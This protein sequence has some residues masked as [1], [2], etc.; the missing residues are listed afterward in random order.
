MKA[1]IFKIPVLLSMTLH[2]LKITRLTY[3]FLMI[4][5]A[6]VTAAQNPI[7][8]HYTIVKGML[9]DECKI[10]NKPVIPVQIT[11]SF[12][13]KLL[14]ENPILIRYQ[15]TNLEA[16]SLDQSISYQLCGS[17]YF[18]IQGEVALT[19]SL[20]LE[21]TLM[22][23]QTNRKVFMY[24]EPQ[25][26]ERLFPMINVKIIETNGT[27]LS[28]IK[29]DF[30]AAP[31]REIL[32]STAHGFTPADTNIGYVD[33]DDII[34]SS[35]RV[36]FKKTNI[37]ETFEFAEPI[38]SID[39]WDISPKANGEILFSLATDGVSK[40]I[41]SVTHDDILSSTGKRFFE[42][43]ILMGRLGLM[44]PTPHLG[45]DAF[46]FNSE[47]EFLFSIVNSGFSETQGITLNGADLLLSSG[48]L[49]LK[50]DKL[51]KNF[52]MPENVNEPNI[53]GFFL[54]PNGEIWFS[55]DSG[56]EDK[57]LGWISHGDIL[58][59]EGYVVLK[60][61]DLLNH[62]SPLEDLADFGLRNFWIVS[63]ASPGFKV[64]TLLSIKKQNDLL[65]LSWTGWAR[66][67]QVEATTDLQTPFRDISDL[68][69]TPWYGVP[70][71][72]YNS[73][74]FRIKAW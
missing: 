22:T 44:P 4:L 39:A 74:F 31:I 23:P 36:L 2:I 9:I 45:I 48:S 18:D 3:P 73:Q 61:L 62:F 37:I 6:Y 41:G 42:G 50:S 72:S 38:P 59:S 12:D 67:F 55:L 1:F 24:Q 27:D 30:F 33:N 11:G 57:N 49:F 51:L 40:K 53:D 25:K 5:V 13:L 26:P 10:C 70:L 56:F 69:V 19:Q 32:F 58:S 20:Q 64:Q 29:L 34:A 14:S 46:H 17:G 63:D 54:W 68:L 21:A 52:S 47:D 35:G 71:P 66:I 60:N 65:T 8:M 16:H 7:T 28:T 43:G 15:I